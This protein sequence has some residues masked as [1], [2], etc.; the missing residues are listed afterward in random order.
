MMEV[1]AV[2]FYKIIYTL[3]AYEED[4]FFTLPPDASYQERLDF[5]VQLMRGLAL[6]LLW[7]WLGLYKKDVVMKT[8]LI[9]L[10]LERIIF[11]F[12]FGQVLQP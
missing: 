2:L 10:A 11:L 3:T 9:F 7:Q 4:Y 8:V 12:T 5:E 6:L 1:S